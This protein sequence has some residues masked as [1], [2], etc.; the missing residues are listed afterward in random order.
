M[1]SDDEKLIQDILSRYAPALRALA[2]EPVFRFVT[3]DTVIALHSAVIALG[4]GLD[5]VRDK[6]L[7]ESALARPL[8]LVAHG[9]TDIHLCAGS[10]CFGLA[11][12]HPFVDGNKRTAFAASTLFCEMNGLTLDCDNAEA[13]DFMM[14][15]ASGR[16]QEDGIASWFE[17]HAQH[18]KDADLLPEH[19]GSVAQPKD[20]P[21]QD[22]AP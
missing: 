20:R 8:N 5:G 16:I 1:P 2:A 4:G 21:G 17:R 14:D 6:G 18:R 11:K 13:F 3:R 15:V 10:L 19:G 22:P 9:T 12:N 7:L